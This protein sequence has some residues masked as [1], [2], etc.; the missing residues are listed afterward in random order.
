[1]GGAIEADVGSFMC[2]YNKINGDWSC[3]NPLTLKRDLKDILG[4]KGYVMSDWGATHS[5]SIMRGLDLEMPGA[6]FMNA[7]LI[8]PAMAAG[9]I[10]ESAIDDSVMRILRPMFAVG[11]MDEPVSAWD[12]KKLEKNVTT[13][14]SLASARPLSAISTVMLKNH[15]GILPLPKK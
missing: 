7:E 5:T 2:G 9:T 4:F 14:A 6:S 1:M 13:D 11:V 8:K 15:Q 3:E 10:T 12:W